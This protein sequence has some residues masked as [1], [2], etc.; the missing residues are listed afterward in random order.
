MTVPPS[1][2]LPV[3]C[4]ASYP[5]T[6]P[7]EYPA[8]SI[9]SV[10]VAPSTR[11]PVTV[12]KPGLA[13]IFSRPLLVSVPV[14]RLILPPLRMVPVLVT[15]V[16]LVV[17]LAPASR[18]M[19]P[20]LVVNPVAVDNVAPK[21]AVTVPGLVNTLVLM[22]SVCPETLEMMVPALLMVASELWTR[23]PLPW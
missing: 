19:V 14:P 22:V 17:Q 16:L 23:P 21:L 18:L 13:P 5:V 11:L 12:V 2:T 6:T 4:R 1:V 10:P 7:R 8:I 15:D 3:T 9:S 20:A